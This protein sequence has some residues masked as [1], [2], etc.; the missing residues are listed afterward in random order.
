MSIRYHRGKEHTLIVGKKEI[1]FND[2]IVFP[3]GTISL[4]WD[5]NTV[6]RIHAEYMINYYKKPTASPYSDY[7]NYHACGGSSCGGIARY[8]SFYSRGG[9]GGS[10]C[11][12]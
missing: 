4:D 3:D 1:E 8:S 11:G 12:G 6:N 10:G 9:C 2:I 5:N 7:S